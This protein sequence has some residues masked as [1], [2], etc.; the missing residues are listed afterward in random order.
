MVGVKECPQGISKIPLKP[1][2]HC[3]HSEVIRSHPSCDDRL[4][5]GSP[6]QVTT[7]SKSPIRT[8]VLQYVLSSTNPGLRLY[9][10]LQVM[11]VK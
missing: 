5:E 2:T 11:P 9:L 4:A 7:M 6:P 8:G 10:S 1:D 3:M